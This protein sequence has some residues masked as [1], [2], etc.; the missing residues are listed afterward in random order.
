MA[1]T[2]DD[3]ISTLNDL[4]ESCKDGQEGFQTAAEGIRN[5]ST[6]SMFQQYAQQRA[7]YAAELRNEVRRLG[8]EP[9]KSG[10]VAAA[11]HRGWIDI[12]S[13]VTGK[14]EHAV[15]VECERGEDSAVKNYEEALSKDLPA[16]VAGL[17]RHQYNAIKQSHDRIRT[18]RD[19][20]RTATA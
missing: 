3:V 12:K 18:L 20:P 11:L 5:S 2:N 6:K 8:G 14:D 16:E 13:V 1:I 19:T 7:Q 9:E 10:S 15:L 4:V 17:I